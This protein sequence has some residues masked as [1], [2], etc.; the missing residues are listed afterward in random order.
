MASDVV[1]FSMSI[2]CG[3]RVC[4]RTPVSYVF[5][6]GVVSW[7]RNKFIVF[8][9]PD[10]M[11]IQI[12]EYPDDLFCCLWPENALFKSRSPCQETATLVFLEV[13]NY[14]CFLWEVSSEPWL[15][16]LPPT[17]SNFSSGFW[18]CYCFWIQWAKLI[19]TLAPGN[20]W[21]FSWD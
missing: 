14:R 17:W 13:C 7:I 20:Q 19:C 16:Y 12:L 21:R 6:A 9:T 1:Q 8:L 15:F 4:Y 18:F 3:M 2:F 5:I 11:H 10:I